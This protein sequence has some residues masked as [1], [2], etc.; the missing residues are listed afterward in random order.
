MTER[1]VHV[2]PVTWGSTW[3]V[4]FP[5][6]IPVEE[7]R[8]RWEEWKRLAVEH[9]KSELLDYWGTPDGVCRGC[10]HL[11]KDW[12]VSAQFPVSVNPIIT[13]RH[14][15]KGI[16]CCGMGYKGKCHE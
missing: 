5:E 7:R 12:C 11:D 10:I 1:N 3:N 16:A 8:E 9:G 2:K 15:I 14:G 13:L 6:N 4:I